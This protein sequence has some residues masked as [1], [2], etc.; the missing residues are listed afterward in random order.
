MKKQLRLESDGEEQ[1]KR[2]SRLESD[3]EEQPK[4]WPKETFLAPAIKD[5]WL[6]PVDILEPGKW[7]SDDIIDHAQYLLGSTFKSVSGFQ[8]NVVFF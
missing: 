7:L 2:H 1:M 5:P 4:K 3:G 8:S 6:A